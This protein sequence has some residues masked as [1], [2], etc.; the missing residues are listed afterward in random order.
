LVLL[1]V[2]GRGYR[3]GGARWLAGAALAVGRARQRGGP[4]TGG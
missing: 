2:A 3:G 1:T 4:A